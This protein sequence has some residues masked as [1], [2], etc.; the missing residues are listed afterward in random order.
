MMSAF[1]LRLAFA[2]AG[3]AAALSIPSCR[4]TPKPSAEQIAP[5]VTPAPVLPP[6]GDH[7]AT[8]PPSASATATKP[9][10]ATQPVKR[11]IAKTA[12]EENS[13]YRV[14][15]TVLSPDDPQAG[16][17]RILAMDKAT[18]KATVSGVFPQQNK[19]VVDTD[20]VERLSVDL[21]MLPI[22]PRQQIILQ[23]DRQG[24]ELSQKHRGR[25]VLQRSHTGLWTVRTPIPRE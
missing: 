22:K 18:R 14:E 17:L 11:D 21:S 15:T 16:W 13:P 1:R 3:L 8:Q 10:P 4:G 7:Q 6:T 19:M 2:I 20:N 9:A 5:P 24:I 23:L 12:Y 25:V